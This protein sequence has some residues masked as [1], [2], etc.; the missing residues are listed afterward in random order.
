VALL[1]GV[2]QIQIGARESFRNTISQTDL[3]AGARGGS[4][5]LLLYTVFRLGSST[6]DI[7]YSSYEKFKSDPAVEWTIP[8]SLGDSHRGFRVVGTTS[9]F[10]RHYRYRHDRTVSFR[11]GRPPEDIFEVALG[12]SVESK[13]QY[14]LGQ[15]IVL[16]H[17]MSSEGGILD[18]SDKPFTIV[19]ILNQTATPVD[20]S[21]Y[22]TL[23]GI[24]AMHIDWQDGAP[25]MPGEEVPARAIHKKDIQ[26]KQITA[27]LLRAR[28]RINSL[29]LQREINTY[30]GEPLQAIIP[31]VA[32]SELWTTFDYADESLSVIA[33][34]VLIV[35][36][37]GM[38]TSLYTSLN[39]RRR[40]LAILR[41]LGLGPHKLVL[42]L[43]I[44]SGL[45]AITGSL[46]GVVI[47]YVLSFGTQ[48][49]VTQR[50][51]LFLPILPL[52]SKA[53]V[54]LLSVMAAGFAVG[55]IPAL[56]AYRNTLADHLSVRL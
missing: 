19:G 52:T 26:I 28:S 1:I 6:N 10:Y 9:D 17:G 22:I 50:F 38:V 34:F 55:F 32:L 23:E 54:Y 42:L 7:S 40:E 16:T 13:L 46:L 30:S 14:H 51:G 36:L 37:L 24:E 25:P 29:A 47:V 39:E 41:V 20:R 12:S 18:H 11:T 35:S 21:L 3:I 2:E 45:L 8:Y 27:F 49:V 15:K 4:L 44:E 43:V 31:G 33:F 56:R 5:Q 48:S 53:Y